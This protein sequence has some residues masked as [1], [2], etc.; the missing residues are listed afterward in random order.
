MTRGSCS[1]CSISMRSA[2]GS[3]EKAR[4]T[5]RTVQNRNPHRHKKEWKFVPWIED[6]G[7]YRYWHDHVPSAYR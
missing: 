3:T 2:D 1:V 7:E 6:D 4:P 5:S